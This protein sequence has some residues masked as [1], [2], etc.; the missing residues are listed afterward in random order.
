MDDSFIKEVLGIVELHVDG[1]VLYA[2]HDTGRGGVEAVLC[3]LQVAVE[4]SGQP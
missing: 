4:S 1:R 3:D 2:G